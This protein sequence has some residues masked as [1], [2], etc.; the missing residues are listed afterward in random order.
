MGGLLDSTQQSTWPMQPTRVISWNACIS[1]HPG[2][3]LQV[4]DTPM[5]VQLAVGQTICWNMRLHS[6]FIKFYQTC[7]FTLLST[8]TTICAYYRSN[9]SIAL[10]KFLLLVS[11]LVQSS[12]QTS[13]W[14]I[15]S[16]L[17]HPFSYLERQLNGPKCE[18]WQPNEYS[19]ALGTSSVR[20]MLSSRVMVVWTSGSETC[21]G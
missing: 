7:F 6:K 16:R 20:V 11:S 3:P 5:D 21:D 17:S 8:H 18:E 4:V 2:D 15:K 10:S 12:T 1:F 9:S 14:F 19:K 13:T